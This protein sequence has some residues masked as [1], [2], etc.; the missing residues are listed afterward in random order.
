MGTLALKGNSL[1]T[2]QQRT[3]SNPNPRELDFYLKDATKK[4]E[5]SDIQSEKAAL[6]AQE[7]E[8]MA[9]LL[10]LPPP[11]PTASSSSSEPKEH[12]SKDREHKS[13]HKEHRHKSKHKDKESRRDRSP[14]RERRRSPDRGRSYDRKDDYDR[15][16]RRY[17]DSDSPRRYEEKKRRRTPSPSPERHAE[18]P[19]RAKYAES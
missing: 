10:G 7:D 13:K 11:I 8:M 19:K 12:R 9:R 17:D 15:D 3:W 6:K 1:Y 16:S 2:S 18:G 5:S 14:G 4:G